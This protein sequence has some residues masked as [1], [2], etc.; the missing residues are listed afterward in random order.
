MIDPSLQST[1]PSGSAYPADGLRPK[2]LAYL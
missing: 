2:L 1:Q